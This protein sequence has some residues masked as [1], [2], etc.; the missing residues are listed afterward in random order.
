[1]MTRA[2]SESYLDDAMNNLGDMMSY[3]VCVCH[4]DIGD[5][6]AYFIAS[7][8]AEKFGTGNPKYVAGMSGVELAR[9]VIRIVKSENTQ[10]QPTEPLLEGPEYWVGWIMAYYQWYTGMRFCDMS[11]YGLGARRVLGMYVLHEA[12]LTK[13]VE[14]ADQII[15]AHRA[16][17][18]A[19]LKRIRKERNLTQQE[20]SAASGVS[21]RMIQLYEQRQS[22]IHAAQASTVIK[23]A[24]VLGCKPADLIE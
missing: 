3:A 12:D 18:P 11:D 19:R 24:Q 5:F 7:G 13:F 1:M 14:S 2:Y 16:Q 6:F 20:L 8:I 23:L 21:L 4:F 9:E 15:A 17:A 10:M 22:D